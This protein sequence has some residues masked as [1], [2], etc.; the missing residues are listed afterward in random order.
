LAPAVFGF[1]NAIDEHIKDPLVW[2][3]SKKIKNSRISIELIKEIIEK[4]GDESEIILSDE[5]Q[6][7]ET[8]RGIMQPRYSRLIDAIKQNGRR[9]LIYILCTKV[10]IALV[11]EIPLD[12]LLIGSVDYAALAFNIIVPPLL[13]WFI[14]S[15]SFKLDEANTRRIPFLSPRP[16]ELRTCLLG[17]LPSMGFSMY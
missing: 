4:K 9:A 8:V 13:L 3:I 17:L 7:E 14:L 2:Y 6:T 12:N 1:S 5:K 16:L 11:V 10:I 15:W